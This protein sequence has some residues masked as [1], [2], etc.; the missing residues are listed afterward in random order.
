MQRHINVRAQ[1]EKARGRDKKG[2]D[3]F[4][5]GWFKNNKLNI[6]EFTISV[7]QQPNINVKLRL[8][9]LCFDVQALSQLGPVTAVFAHRP[10]YATSVPDEILWCVEFEN[11]AAFAEN[12]DTVVV[13][14][15][16]ESMR[17]RYNLILA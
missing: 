12:E 4:E 2:A 11:L 17:Y 16:F 7:W 5:I 3:I 10:K 15:S 1:T 6:H 14:Y 9:A 13:D 8:H